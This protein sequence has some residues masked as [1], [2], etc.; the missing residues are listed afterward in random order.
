MQHLDWRDDD[1]NARNLLGYQR[2]SGAYLGAG[3][4]RAPLRTTKTLLLRMA[5]ER[6]LWRDAPPAGATF[7]P[8]MTL[9]F[10]GGLVRGIALRP[11]RYLAGSDSSSTTSS[12]TDGSTNRDPMRVL[13]VTDELP[14]RN[15]GGGNIRQA[16]LLDELP[17]VAST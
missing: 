13:W 11:R 6:P 12:R 16:M 4:R 8:R 7:G 5:H 14:D 15:G 9:V 2:G 3:L 10:A 1:E 17:L